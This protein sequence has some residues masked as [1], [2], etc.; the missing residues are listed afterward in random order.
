MQISIINDENVNTDKAGCLGLVSNIVDLA[1]L[2]QFV[3]CGLQHH[4]CCGI[5]NS[6]VRRLDNFQKI[7][8]LQYDFDNG[9]SVEYVIN[10]L[11]EYNIIVMASKNHMKDKGDG[12]GEIPRFHVFLPLKTPITDCN[13]Y[14]FVIKHIAEKYKIAIDRKAV[15][16]TR[17]FYKHSKF[18]YGKISANNIDAYIYETNYKFKLNAERME[19]IARDKFLTEQDSK[20]HISEQDRIK[21]VKQIITNKVGYAISGQSGNNSTF[22]AA[23]YCIRFGLKDAGVKEVMDWYNINYCKPKW[24]KNGLDNKIKYAKKTIKLSDYFSASYILKILDNN[25]EG[26]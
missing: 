10:E 8:F 20:H 9:T 7:W 17:Y 15:D 1:D 6:N 24:S 11:K 19:N 3:K 18:L 26:F 21:A 22:V 25:I 2:K 5:F 23:C 12:K 13:F 4:I 14:S 16:S